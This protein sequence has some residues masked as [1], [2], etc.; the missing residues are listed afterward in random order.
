VCS[1]GIPFL[2]Y[3]GFNSIKQLNYYK[4]VELI[5]G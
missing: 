3:A 2:I 4:L 5:H 1:L